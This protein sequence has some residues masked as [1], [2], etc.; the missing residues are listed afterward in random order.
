MDRERDS[1]KPQSE[2]HDWDCN[3]VTPVIPS[4][5]KSYSYYAQ[6]GRGVAGE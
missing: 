3:A 2:V 5:Y 4:L 1:P 6:A